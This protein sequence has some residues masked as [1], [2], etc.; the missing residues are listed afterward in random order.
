MIVLDLYD[1]N[2]LTLPL[3]INP[4]E[5]DKMMSL[6]SHNRLTQSQ[7]SFFID[8]FGKDVRW[9][10]FRIDLVDRY[11]RSYHVVAEVVQFDVEVLRP[12]SM[13]RFSCHL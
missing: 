3:E 11:F 8:W 12:R 6:P 13:L 4:I 10:I 5:S 9:L 1:S 2:Y 7:Q